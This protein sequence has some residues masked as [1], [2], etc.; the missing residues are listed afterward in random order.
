MQRYLPVLVLLCLVALPTRAGAQ[1]LQLT[2]EAG[3]TRFL[4]E[5]QTGLGLN[6]F[7]G[8][9]AGPLTIEGQV[10]YHRG[11]RPELAP[12][13]PRSL[14]TYVPIMAGGRL[15]LPLGFAE[16]WIGAHGGLAFVARR[17]ESPFA[18]NY[19]DREWEPAA[20]A[21]LGVDLGM[22]K[23]K[24]GAALWYDLVL[25]RDDPLRAL[26][27]GLALTIGL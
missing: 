7:P 24:L 21:G 2:A 4:E 26:S 16:P 3:V 10:G 14:T 22:G 11:D 12:N 17:I 8:I 13:G 18:A 6:V 1:A 9:G 15:G 19:V 5:A 25:D 20:N 27:A 23:V